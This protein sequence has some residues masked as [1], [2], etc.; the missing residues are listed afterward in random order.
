MKKIGG[1]NIVSVSFPTIMS[2]LASN[3][4]VV[5][6]SIIL[7]LDEKFSAILSNKICTLKKNGI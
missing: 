2:Y 1:K 7:K 6:L 3:L 4:T 5:G